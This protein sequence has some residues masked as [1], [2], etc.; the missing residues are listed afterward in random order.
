MLR[1]TGPRLPIQGLM[2]QNGV[3]SAITRPEEIMWIDTQFP[4]MKICGKTKQFLYLHGTDL[5]LVLLDKNYHFLE[6]KDII[7]MCQA[8][9]TCFD[10]S[11]HAGRIANKGFIENCWLEQVNIIY[12]HVDRIKACV[13]LTVLDRIP[14][15][16]TYANSAEPVQMPQ[17]AASEL[18][19]P[20]MLTYISVQY[21][22]YRKHSPE[23]PKSTNRLIQMIKAG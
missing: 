2:K 1:T 17:N 19:L 10:S 11:D 23:N 14:V 7:K 6:N 22:T 18:G 12:M 21:T 3:V 15:W 4:S 9:R 5:W 16:G 8:V 20:C 13:F